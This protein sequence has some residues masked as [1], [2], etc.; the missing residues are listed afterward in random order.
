MVGYDLR[1]GCDVRRGSQVAEGRGA[2]GAGRG[3]RHGLA[4]AGVWYR[5]WMWAGGAV[6]VG[7]ADGRVTRSLR[8]PRGEIA[9]AVVVVVVVERQVE[10]STTA[11]GVGGGGSVDHENNWL[12]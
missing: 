2:W 11:S 1:A 10:L 5:E 6:F 3:A 7:Q 8:C 4:W 9:A 12:R